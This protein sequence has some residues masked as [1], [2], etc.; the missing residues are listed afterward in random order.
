MEALFKIQTPKINREA[1]QALKKEYKK[2]GNWSKKK[3]L[4]IENKH[5]LSYRQVYKWHWDRKNSNGIINF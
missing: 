2:G 1:K 3:M 4:E 5:G